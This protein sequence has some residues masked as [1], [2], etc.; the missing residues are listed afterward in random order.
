MR[1]P[2]VASRWL[3]LLLSLL[4][5]TACQ[6]ERRRGTVR[7]AYYWSTTWAMDSAKRRFIREHKVSRLYVRYFDVVRRAAD[8]Q[9]QPNATLRFPDEAEPDGAKGRQASAATV[10]RGVEVVPVVYV[11]NDCLRPSAG[12]P[13][14][15]PSD[16]AAKVLRRIVQM[17]QAQGIGGVKEVQV[18]CDWTATTAAAYFS[19]LSAL[20]RQAHARGLQ[21]SATIR[22]HQLAQEA[23]PVDRG[24]LMMYNTGD[25]R[26]IGQRKPILDMADAAPYLR[27][28]SA[29]PLPLAT[30]YP[31]F[32]WRILFREGRFVG[33]L[34]QDDDQP[35]LPGDSIV[36]R[37]PELSDILQAARAI[38]Q[39][40]PDANEEV[41]LFD[42]SAPNIH[43]FNPHDYETIYTHP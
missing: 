15:A 42:L 25:A 16:L 40:R 2:S 7:A 3:I 6:R 26:Q 38:G 4:A 20:R 14:A 17:S 23:P 8:G 30:A 32:T 27:H 24:V 37:R 1:N 28:L 10:P 29:Y 34:H 39:R 35:V 33:F 19:F 9:P 5:L 41:I 36:V 31:L 11:V 13:P 18:D 43:R 22:L 12:S 21:L